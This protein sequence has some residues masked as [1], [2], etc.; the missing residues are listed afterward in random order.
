MQANLFELYCWGMNSI[1]DVIAAIIRKYF[2]D[3]IGKDP[4]H[5]HY[6]GWRYKDRDQT[7]NKNDKSEFSIFGKG[8]GQKLIKTLVEPEYW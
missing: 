2:D 3:I 1:C 5:V 6:R 7:E 4:I 8:N